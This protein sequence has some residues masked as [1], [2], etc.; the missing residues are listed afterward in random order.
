[1]AVE[2]HPFKPFV[3]SGARALILGSFPGKDQSHLT[4][5]EEHWFYGTKRNTFW[6]I[7]ELAFTRPLPTTT[8][9]QQLLTELKC[10]IADI[11]LQ[12]ERTAAN[13]ADTNL[14]IITY[15]DKALQTIFQQHPIQTVYCTSAFVATLFRKLFPHFKEVLTLPS[16]SPRYA[17][18]TM[19]QKADVYKRELGKNKL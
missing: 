18:M 1:M 16:P 10:G 5:S 19:Q 7:M 6:K 8:A 13:N 14:R 3:P 17:R 12:A 2:T 9:K 15:N 4:I 11:I